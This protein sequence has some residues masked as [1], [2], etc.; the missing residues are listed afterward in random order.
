MLRLH[1][2]N[3]YQLIFHFDFNANKRHAR[4]ANVAV[5]RTR[6]LLL[7]IACGGEVHTYVRTRF[8]CIKR[9]SVIARGGWIINRTCFLT[10]ETR[11][12]ML[13]LIFHSFSFLFL[14]SFTSFCSFQRCKQ[15]STALFLQALVYNRKELKHS[16]CS[17]Y[18]SCSLL[19]SSSFICSGDTYACLCARSTAYSLQ[20]I[21][22]SFYR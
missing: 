11:R 2:S 17:L 4:L 14:F 1:L 3:E 10:T 6:I 16:Y 19:F 5:N 15:Y 8:D 12:K 21:L 7:E 18:F 20:T 13:R 9:S 22:F